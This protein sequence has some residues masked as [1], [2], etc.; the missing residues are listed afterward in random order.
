MLF[1][2]QVSL[3][4]EAA[5]RAT[6]A[7]IEAIDELHAAY[8]RGAIAND[9]ATCVH[10]NREL[11]QFI[12]GLADNPLALDVL[13]SRSG[14]VDAFRRAHGYGVGRLDIVVEQHAKIIAAMRAGDVDVVALSVLD[15]TESSRLDLL[16]LL[17]ESSAARS[18]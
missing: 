6:A 7:D 1:R 10:A 14:L 12:D 13:R 2:S 17:R 16:K 8:V 3:S 5:R 9:A 4:R 18:H 15:H 11:H